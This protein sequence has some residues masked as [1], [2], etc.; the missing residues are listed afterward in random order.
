MPYDYEGGAAE[1]DYVCATS[2][3]YKALT[4]NSRQ[5]AGRSMNLKE[6]SDGYDHRP[7]STPLSRPLRDAGE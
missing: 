3:E 4:A 7:I 2:A 5:V 6:L 1:L